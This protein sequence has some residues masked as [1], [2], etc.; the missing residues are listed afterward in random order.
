ML[1]F[2]P[3]NGKARASPVRRST[4]CSRRSFTSG[5]YTAAV[6]A[7]RPGRVE[8]HGADRLGRRDAHQGQRLSPVE[9]GEEQCPRRGG[10][11]HVAARRIHGE[12][13]AG[14]VTRA[15]AIGRAAGASGVERVDASFGGFRTRRSAWSPA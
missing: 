10:E 13:V 8:S 1:A 2:A 6:A 9:R 7:Q 15:T 11:E 3:G 5:A 4:T 12:A 14:E